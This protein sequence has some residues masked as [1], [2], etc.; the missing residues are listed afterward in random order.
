M[1]LPG[2]GTVEVVGESRHQIELEHVVGGRE[3]ISR[4]VERWAC[5]FREPDNPYDRNAVGVFVDGLEVGY[6]G[7]DDAI[8]YAPLLDSLACSRGA[9][10]VCRAKIVGGWSRPGDRGHFGVKLALAEAETL[11]P[12]D[13]YRVMS[14]QAVRGVPEPTVVSWEMVARP[15]RIFGHRLR[16]AAE[17][18]LD[19][20]ADGS[21]EGPSS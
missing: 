13:D 10:A 12:S 1:L 5:L 19:R 21:G 20:L 14:E 17:R 2:G 18:A 6:L 8:R 4:D 16:S 9:V 11:S 15:D 3:E 7:R